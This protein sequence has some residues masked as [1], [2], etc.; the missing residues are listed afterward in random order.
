MPTTP[1]NTG[2]IPSR[3]TLPVEPYVI[4]VVAGVGIDAERC[5]DV[6]RTV[7]GVARQVMAKK[8]IHDHLGVSSI[9][10][11][12]DGLKVGGNQWKLRYHRR[13]MREEP[14][15]WDL[16]RRAGPI[17][18]LTFLRALARTP[19]DDFRSK[20]L[21][22]DGMEALENYWGSDVFARRVSWMKLPL[23]APLISEDANGRGFP[24][25]RRRLV[26]ATSP[27]TILQ[28]FREAGRRIRDRASITVGGSAALML[29]AI[30]TRE[31]EDIDLVDEVPAPLRADPALMHELTD[32]YNLSLTHFQ[33]HYLP[34]G[35]NG[36]TKS[37]GQFDNLTVRVVDTLDLLAGKLF[38]SRTK[39]LDDLR[40]AL[41]LI[42]KTALAAHVAR[43]CANFVR[44]EKSKR[45]GE[46]NW[47]IL[48]GE[49]ALP[50]GV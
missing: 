45:A 27:E 20:L 9:S 41:P 1:S 38:S 40:V 49:Q 8:L 35:W 26:K 12:V 15:A 48:T 22:R 5:L 2:A 37:L 31:T 29:D 34:D 30:L 50:S 10:L 28:L 25:I 6:D 3:F 16:V 13:R 46:S 14:D 47:Y 4:G 19:I 42:G 43:N 11:T 18:A 24:S 44:D 36:R 23:T 7:L 33:S 21:R 39:D 17:D 32:R